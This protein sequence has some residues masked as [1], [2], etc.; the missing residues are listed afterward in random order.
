MSFRGT[1]GRA[2]KYRMEQDNIE[3]IKKAVIVA[4]PGRGE[5]Q[6]KKAGL[7]KRSQSP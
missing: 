7:Y 3:V 2:F 4:V 5:G 6:E 1:D